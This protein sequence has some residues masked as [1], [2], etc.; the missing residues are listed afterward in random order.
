MVLGLRLAVLASGG[1]DSGLALWRV[2]RDG[3]QVTC[4][5][6]IL[7]KRLDSWM[8]HVPNVS[9]VGLFG[10]AAGFEVV[11]GETGG[12][13]EMEVEDLR[14]VLAGLDVDGV[15]SGAVASK[16]QKSRVDDVCRELGLVSVAPLWG[17]DPLELLRETADLG[18]EVVFTSVSALGF[19]ENWLGRLLDENTIGELVELNRRFGVSVVGEGGEYE[20]LVL[21]APYFREKKI[22]LVETEKVWDGQNGWLKIGKA[23]LMDK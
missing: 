21:D 6:A 12:I 22:D 18:F 2:L 3:H 13:K 15:V 20:T 23:R 16:Y 5:V 19:D 9:L 1:K 14:R 4:L 10:Q 11:W 7:S 17:D 8:F